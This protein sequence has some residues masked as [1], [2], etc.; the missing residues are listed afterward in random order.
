M[1]ASPTECLHRQL[2]E[3]AL[4]SFF[5]KQQHGN[6]LLLCGTVFPCNFQLPVTEQC[7]A[8]RYCPTEF[9]NMNVNLRRKQLVYYQYSMQVQ[10]SMQ[11]LLITDAYKK[12]TCCSSLCMST[13]RARIISRTHNNR[14]KNATW[15]K[16]HSSL[17]LNHN[18]TQR[19]KLRF[20]IY[21]T[22]CLFSHTGRK[23]WRDLPAKE[24]YLHLHYN[25]ETPFEKNKI[26]NFLLQSQRFTQTFG[27]LWTIV[28]SMQLWKT[29][30]SLRYLYRHYHHGYITGTSLYV[31]Y[32][33]YYQISQHFLNSIMN[34]NIITKMKK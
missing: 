32:Q 11:Q 31:F 16:A 21:V 10:L 24:V 13:D 2:K 15:L 4:S 30:P 19:R 23:Y 27:N 3:A 9:M 34:I 29:E 25:L 28:F 20:Y 33:H 12:H 14:V 7:C 26:K 18:K 22:K 6:S 1:L 8:Y 17:K 5:R